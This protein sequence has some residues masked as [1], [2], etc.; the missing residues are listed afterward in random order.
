MPEL[1]GVEAAIQELEREEKKL[2]DVIAM[3]KRITASRSATGER[4]P[5]KRSHLSAAAR[6][7]ISEAAKKRW[8]ELRVSKKAT[9]TERSRNACRARLS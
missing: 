5:R 3:L 6:K 7:R 1:F 4:S 9:A 8:A 2:R